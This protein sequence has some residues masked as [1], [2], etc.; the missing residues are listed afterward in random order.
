M[1]IFVI[2]LLAPAVSGIFFLGSKCKSPFPSTF[3]YQYF[4]R[5]WSGLFKCPYDPEEDPS[6]VSKIGMF[7]R[8][9]YMTSGQTTYQETSV[10][11]MSQLINPNYPNF[12]IMHGFTDG[13]KPGEWMETVARK[14][15]TDRNVNVILVDYNA[16]SNC[17]YIYLAKKVTYDLGKYLANSIDRWGLQLNHTRILAHSLGAHIAGAAGAY[18]TKLTGE[19]LARIDG[20]DPAAPLYG[21]D[22]GLNASCAKFVQVLHTSK[23]FGTQTR[24][25]HSDFYAN[26]G[27]PKQPGCLLDTCN[28]SRATELFYASCFHE[29]IFMGTSCNGS[30][31]G[32]SRFGLYND[33]KE[34]CFQFN[35][36]ACFGYADMNY[37][38]LTYL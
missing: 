27:K 34:G 22:R 3:D 30:D 29:Y 13:V 32:Q 18:L 25:G 14:I 4:G 23:Y 9:F 7:V 17:N 20:L 11:D 1:K 35:T 10:F 5:I 38:F 36:T 12:I 21:T 16:L 31:V 2:F 24:L 8:Y 37:N 19:Q 33:E 6:L 15:S 26:K 28:H